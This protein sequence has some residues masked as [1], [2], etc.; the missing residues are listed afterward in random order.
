A[1]VEFLE[2]HRG[3]ITM[4]CGGQFVLEPKSPVYRERERFSITRVYPYPDQDLK[5][6]LQYDVSEGMTLEEAGPVA[7][8]I[9]ALPLIRPPDFHLVSRSHLVFLPLPRE[10]AFHDEAAVA[11]T[12]IDQA[13]DLVPLRRSDLMPE[14]LPFNLDDVQERL[15][16]GSTEP[17]APRPTDYVFSPEREAL[18]EVGPDGLAL[19]RA[20]S[21]DFELAD[22]LAAVGEDGRDATVTFLRDLEQRQFISWKA[23]P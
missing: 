22:I 21:G 9:E 6:W 19:L 10:D 7:R 2:R 5:T 13:G 15:R 14:R 3:N 1:T 12:P 18:I 23:S 8:E 17:L 11:M 16:D 20:C 4:L